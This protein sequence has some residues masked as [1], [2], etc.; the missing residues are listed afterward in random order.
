MEAESIPKV[1]RLVSEGMR[2]RQPEREIVAKLVDT[3]IPAEKAPALYGA[4][5]HAIQAGVQA[6]FT[7]GLSAP[8]GP[9]ADP[10]LAEA[11]RQGRAAFAVAVRNGWLMRFALPIVLVLLL[12]LGLIGWLSGWWGK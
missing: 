12:T 1:V 6:G 11:F 4:I 10:L 2:Q 5:R 9:P 7:G 3:G 8:G